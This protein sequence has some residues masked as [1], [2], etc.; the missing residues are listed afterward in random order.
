MQMFLLL[1]RHFFGRFFHHPFANQW[2]LLSD[3]YFFIVYSMVVMGLVMVFQWDALF[4][5]R[6]DYLILTPLPLSGNAIFAGKTT[7]LVIF[8]GLFLVMTNFFCT[9]L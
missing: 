5:D 3:Y 9:L 7:A 2:I 6:R 4:P 1:V 8:L